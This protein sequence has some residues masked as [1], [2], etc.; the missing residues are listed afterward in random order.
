MTE[1]RWKIGDRVSF[2]MDYNSF[3]EGI[4][5]DIL[6]RDIDPLYSI[7]W[8]DGFEDGENNLLAEWELNDIDESRE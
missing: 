8:D 3:S 5:R 4:V 2:E 6:E 1:T 7:E